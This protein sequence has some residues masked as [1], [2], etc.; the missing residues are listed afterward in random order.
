MHVF[1]QEAFI[2]Y[3]PSMDFLKMCKTKRQPLNNLGVCGQGVIKNYQKTIFWVW[4]RG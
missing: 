1:I 3:A 2:V 4:R